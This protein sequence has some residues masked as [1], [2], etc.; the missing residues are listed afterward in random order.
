MKKQAS[1]VPLYVKILIGM[2]LGLMVSFLAV[3]FKFE[4]FVIDWIKPLGIIFMRLLKFIAIPLVFISLVKGVINLSNIK[5]LSSIGLRTLTIYICTTIAAVLLGLVLAKGFAP[6]ELI[7][8]ESAQQLRSQYSDSGVITLNTDMQNAGP[9]QVLIDI[10]PENM[11]QAFSSNN[12]M[13]Q[14]IF[15]AILFGVGL[16]LIDKNKLKPIYDLVDSLDELLLKIV[17]LIMLFA[18]YGVFG[19]LSTIIIDTSGNMSILGALG[20]YALVVILG[21]FILAFAFYPILIKIFTNTPVKHYLKSVV[22]V[23]L[24]AFSTSSSA[25]TLPLTMDV[26]VKKLNISE[27]IASFV[28]PVGVTINMD[29]TSCYQ[30]I[31]TIFM[32]QVL[33]ISLSP[34][35]LVLLVG[36]TTLA[37]I[38]TPGVPGASIVV[39]VMVLTTMGIPAEGLALILGID[40]PLDMMRTVVN[41]T[42]DLTVATIVEHHENKKALE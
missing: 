15:I 3:T 4:T 10:F 29:G 14:V 32:A 42:G 2:V 11:M 17:D 24:L 23:Q 41:V 20:F 39:Q 28:L 7:S 26:A 25:A 13:L 8:A 9:L 19:L 33:G 30:M 27:K 16:L 1:Q 31:A 37:S 38:G 40:R 22:P 34:T 6:G 12:S 21:L 5:A 35:D 18:P 36:L